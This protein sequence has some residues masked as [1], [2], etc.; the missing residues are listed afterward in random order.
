MKDKGI[1]FLNKWLNDKYYYNTI[2]KFL[3]YNKLMDFLTNLKKDIDI[4]WMNYNKES[5]NIVTL[6]EEIKKLFESVEWKEE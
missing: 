2:Y 3:T 4:A 1:E 6:P 5:K